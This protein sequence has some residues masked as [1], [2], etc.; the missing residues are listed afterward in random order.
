MV[1]P[2]QAV[3]SIVDWRDRVNQVADLPGNRL[4][5]VDRVE[6]RDEGNNIEIRKTL[7]KFEPEKGKKVNFYNVS[8]ISA[9]YLPWLCLWG[10]S[11]N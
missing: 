10:P 9:F 6:S 7:L 3:E 4:R 8:V 5:K 11:L 1:F 2:L